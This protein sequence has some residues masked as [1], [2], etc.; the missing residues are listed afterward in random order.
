MV[1]VG[2]CLAAL[3]GLMFLSIE[4][5]TQ[6]S[7]DEVMSS[8]TSHEGDVHLRGQVEIGSVDT[9]SFS[10]ELVGQ[11]HSLQVDYSDVVVPDGFEEGHTIAIKGNLVSGSS[12]WLLEA[13]E[14]QTGCPSKYSE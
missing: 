5:Q 6:Y 7:I 12:G 3:V 8:P 2:A 1:L 10:F 4:P 9:S 11:T 14:I 13:Q